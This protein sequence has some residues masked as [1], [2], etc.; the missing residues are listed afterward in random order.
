[1]M[2]TM[3]DELDPRVEAADAAYLPCDNATIKRQKSARQAGPKAKTPPHI[4]TT[5]S[6]N[7]PHT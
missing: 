5:E 4:T 3:R 1:M 6:N 2:T 7:E